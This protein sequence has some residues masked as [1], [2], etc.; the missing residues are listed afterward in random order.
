MAKNYGSLQIKDRV[1][2]VKDAIL[3][4]KLKRSGPIEWFLQVDAKEAKYGGILWS[5]RAYSDNYLSVYMTC[6]I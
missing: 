6:L 1:F 4:G 3:S 2:E 5:P